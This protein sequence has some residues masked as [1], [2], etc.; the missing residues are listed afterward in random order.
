[1]KKQRVT[2][3]L[4]GQLW[5]EFRAAC[6]RR[7]Q[8]ASEVTEMGIQNQMLSW[9][10]DADSEKINVAT[11]VAETPRLEDTQHTNAEKHDQ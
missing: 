2:L 6:V 1:M 8:S 3:Y 10:A 4:D 11:N 9:A 7:G 5:R